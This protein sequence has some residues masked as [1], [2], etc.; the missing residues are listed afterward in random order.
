MR[1]AELIVTFGPITQFGC[2]SACSTV[3][4][5]MRSALHSRNGPPEAVIVI[6]SDGRRIAPAER[7]EEGVV[8]RIHRQEHRAGPVGRLHHRGARRRPASPCWRAPPCGPRR[9]R[10]RSARRRPRRRSPRRRDPPRARPL[11]A[12]LRGRPRPRCQSRRARASAPRSRPDRRLRRISPRVRSPAAPAP[13]RR[14]PRRPTRTDETA[15]RRCDHPGAGV[16][17]RAGGPE[18]DEA[19]WRAGDAGARRPRGFRRV[20]IARAESSALTI[21]TIRSRYRSRWELSAATTAAK[22]EAAMKASSRSMRP[23]WP[24]MRWLESLTPNRRLSADSNRSPEFRHDRDRKPQP[25]E[26]VEPGRPGARAGG[27]APPRRAPRRSRPTRSCPA[28][29]G[30][31]PRTANQPPGEIG[32]DIDAPDD[33]EQPQDRGKP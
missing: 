31:Q 15:R 10:R 22:A 11:R 17:D 33:R 26:P 9:R 20:S 18:N 32:R 5:A 4:A 16:A 8:L 7:L 21:R 30:P 12:R 19:S 27:R 1:L 29:R 14:G 2:A 23:P 3:A 24:G 6:F 28:K 25:E 13:R